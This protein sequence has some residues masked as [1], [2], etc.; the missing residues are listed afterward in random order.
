MILEETTKVLY[1]QKDS[2]FSELLKYFPP[3][4]NDIK[5]LYKEANFSY[6]LPG[7]KNPLKALSGNNIYNIEIID[8]LKQV[9]NELNSSIPIHKL[10]NPYDI[11][12]QGIL[13]LI[14]R[15]WG[16][17]GIKILN[18]EVIALINKV[19]NNINK[20]IE[21]ETN[22]IDFAKNYDTEMTNQQL[23]EVTNILDKSNIKSIHDLSQDDVENLFSKLKINQK[24]NDKN[25][26][27][28]FN[29]IGK[30]PFIHIRKKYN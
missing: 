5:D 29:K 18:S 30:K 14:L 17:L 9:R 19:I 21:L 6:R 25:V 24:R 15:N 3:V 22:L 20:K 1:H 10:Y 23:N 11:E 26:N 2:F 13:Y 16:T 8:G 28:T 7:Y 4:S 12:H 27:T